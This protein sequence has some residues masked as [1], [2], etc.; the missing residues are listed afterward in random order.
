[1]RTTLKKGQS[2]HVSAKTQNPPQ[3]RPDFH[4][5]SDK[6][7]EQGEQ[8]RPMVWKDESPESEI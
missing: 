3:A 1:M 5:M 6:T 7:T 2:C 8:S 4:H